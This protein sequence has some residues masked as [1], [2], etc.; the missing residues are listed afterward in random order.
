MEDPRTG[1]F[2]N[3]NLQK[4]LIVI[5]SIAIVFVLIL[6]IR[7]QTN[8]AKPVAHKNVES[9]NPV[10]SLT[11]SLLELTDIDIIELTINEKNINLEVAKS[12]EKHEKGLMFRE[13]LDEN[14]GMIFIFDTQRPLSFWMKNTLVPL[15][16]IFVDNTLTIVKIHANTRIDQIVETYDSDKPS[17]F[18]IELSGGNAAKLGLQEGMSLKESIDASLKK[19]VMSN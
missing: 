9:L 19:T 1:K 14:N 10:S 16:M 12:F 5:C 13:N 3:T 18:V 11:L 15:D 8:I 4:F 7:N 6:I 2:L 17:Q